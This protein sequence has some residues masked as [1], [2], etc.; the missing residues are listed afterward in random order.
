[1]YIQIFQKFYLY[2][3]FYSVATTRLLLSEN[4][5]LLETFEIVGVIG[6]KVYLLEKEDKVKIVYF[7]IHFLRHSWIFNTENCSQF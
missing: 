6:N 4:R 3:N 2:A 7:L 1:M 5:T